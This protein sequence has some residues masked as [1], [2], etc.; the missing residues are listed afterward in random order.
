[1]AIELTLYE[2]GGIVLMA[3]G[4]A[5]TDAAAVSRLVVAF[6]AKKAGI[7]PGQIRAYDKAT[8]D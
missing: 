5:A 6:L 4:L 1:M 3:V 8:T 2:L 7:D